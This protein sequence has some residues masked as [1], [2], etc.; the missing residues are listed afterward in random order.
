M[1]PRVL[2][3]STY[4]HPVIGGV[5]SHARQL[6]RSLRARGFPV[7]VV[8]KRADRH[9][10]PVEAIDGVPVH[11]IAPAG[12]R[13]PSGKWLVIPNL[14]LTLRQMRSQAD[15][16]VCVDFR[17]IGVAAIATGLPVIA[18]AE[19]AGVLA[20]ADGKSISGLAPETIVTKALKAPVRSVYRHAAAVVCIG[21]DLEREA[22]RAGWPR[23]RVTYLPHGVE[24]DRFRPAD[25]RERD[26]LRSDIGWP[27]TTPIVLFV[28]RLSREKGVMDL[29]EA[30]GLANRGD[31]ILAL[32]GPDMMGHPWDA[33]APGRAFVAAKG[34]AGSVRF[35]GA[36]P[37]PERFYR[38]ADIFVQ[39]SHFEALGN[40]AIEAMASGLAVVSSGV[41]GLADFCIDN[42]NAVLSEPRSPRSLAGAIETLLGD[43]ALRARLGAA[44]RTTAVEQFEL[45][46][47]MDRYAALVEQVSQGAPVP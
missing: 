24:V 12:D 47:L 1:K 33:G 29:L 7:E 22:L 15:V 6:A 45:Q 10:S 8:T 43:S 30:W 38:A 16:I 21:R 23:D 46:A 3:V 5:E 26:R 42:V 20:G 4:Y 31:A 25:A 37:D 35:E 2:I 34:L 40:T 32:V 41:G 27:R 18:Q 19:V 17:G 28:G 44:A 11:R 13:R 9:D 14:W 36:R 39:P